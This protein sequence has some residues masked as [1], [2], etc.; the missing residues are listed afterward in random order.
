MLDYRV[1]MSRA[2]DGIDA[3]AAAHQDQR[4]DGHDDDADAWANMRQSQRFRRLQR[5]EMEAIRREQAERSASAW[6]KRIQHRLWRML[7][8]TMVR[9][10][11]FGVWVIFSLGI[12]IFFLVRWFAVERSDDHNCRLLRDSERWG[13]LAKWEVLLGLYW[14]ISL[15]SLPLVLLVMRMARSQTCPRYCGRLARRELR[16]TRDLRPA[17]PN[18]FQELVRRGLGGHE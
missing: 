6:L 3:P 13:H 11:L 9:A 8:G 15:C 4:D 17:D 10:T 2:A 7:L 16:P 14:L 1:R 18:D 5:K 12:T